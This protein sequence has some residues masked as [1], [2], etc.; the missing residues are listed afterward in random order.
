[1]RAAL[2]VLLVLLALPLSAS[3]TFEPPAPADQSFVLLKVDEIWRD[4]CVPFRPQVTRNGSRVE[5]VWSIPDGGC[6]LATTPWV[7]TAP[8]GQFEAG[9]YEV[10]VRV[11]EGDRMTDFPPLTLVVGDAT[12]AL[13]IVPNVVSTA[14]GEIVIPNLCIAAGPPLLRYTFLIDGVTVPSR[15]EGCVVTL[16]APPHAAGAVDVKVT[17]D[18][19]VAE[20]INGLRYVDPA[21]VPDPSLYER[22]LIPVLFNGPGAFG[23]QWRTDV[24]LTNGDLLALPG[25]ETGAI[26]SLPEV[27]RPL[28]RI[29]PRETV[30]LSSL[31]GNRPSGLL[32][33]LPRGAPVHFGSLIRDISRDG[34]QWGTEMPIVRESDARDVVQLFQVPFDSRY[35]L[36]LRI[37]AMDGVTAGVAITAHAQTPVH[38][39]AI[40]TGPCEVE[41]CN[42]NQPSYV[43]VDLGRAFPSLTG[44]VPISIRSSS[45]ATPPLW[46]FVT[47]TNNETQVVTVIS[48]Q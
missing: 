29:A 3:F 21:A 31:F 17:S 22:V 10:I 7:A 30:S 37:Y 32:L 20:V 28:P 11:D 6:P 25:F 5:V 16:T 43:S 47:V 23:S 4:G 18:V 35:R 46:A 36:Q 48:P 24:T 1:M 14:G 8:L 44:T 40:V 42:S 9:T 45:D 33:F 34:A 27:A 26:E 41:P 19:F 12:P 13:R 2:S 15:V 39:N 38:A